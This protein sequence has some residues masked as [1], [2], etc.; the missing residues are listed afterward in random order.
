MQHV[1]HVDDSVDRYSQWNSSGLRNHSQMGIL[2]KMFRVYVCNRK[3]TSGITVGLNDL[4]AKYIVKWGVTIKG[5]LRKR[6]EDRRFNLQSLHWVTLLVSQS[7]QHFATMAARLT[8]CWLVERYQVIEA[9]RQLALPIHEGG[10][11][12]AHH[13]A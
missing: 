8:W 12:H 13:F 9:P 11:S 7:I 4:V 1:T 3:Q 5:Q 2:S 6:M 10:R